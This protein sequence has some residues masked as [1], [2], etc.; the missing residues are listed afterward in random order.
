MVID[1]LKRMFHN[2]FFLTLHHSCLSPPSN[3]WQSIVDFP[4][5][6]FVQLVA[7][8]A[9][10][11]W[12]MGTSHLVP[13]KEALERGEVDRFA[14]V[15]ET[16]RKNKI[17]AKNVMAK[18]WWN[19]AWEHIHD[20]LIFYP[21]LC[22]VLIRHSY[23]APSFVYWIPR[24]VIHTKLLRVEV[25]I[26]FLFLS[27]STPLKAFARI[28]NHYFFNKGFFPNDSFLLD[29]VSIIRHIPAVIVQVRWSITLFFFQLNC[30]LDATTAKYVISSGALLVPYSAAHKTF[31]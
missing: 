16:W 9:W 19:R 27:F 8:R 2:L 13:K 22:D 12:E 21:L 10:T 6:F 23:L 25:I 28:E 7:A 4:F 1:Y 31:I 17:M 29:N 18:V 14:L 5:F 24:R 30:I 15:S 26:A 20:Q 11:R 3:H